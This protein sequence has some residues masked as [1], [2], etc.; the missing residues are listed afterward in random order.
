M[1]TDQQTYLITL[2]RRWENPCHPWGLLCPLASGVGEGVR[3]RGHPLCSATACSTPSPPCGASRCKFA[4]LDSAHILQARR[5]GCGEGGGQGSALELG[6]RSS[7]LTPGQYPHRSI[8]RVAVATEVHD[9]RLAWELAWVADRT[10][11][12]CERPAPRPRWRSPCWVMLRTGRQ[13]SLERPW[14]PPPPG[15][16]HTQGL[17]RSS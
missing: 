12:C 1:Q 10:R 14:F 7:S 8:P 17:L 6:A 13:H 2:G 4:S 9:V 5:E 15:A 3:K 11:T 16:C